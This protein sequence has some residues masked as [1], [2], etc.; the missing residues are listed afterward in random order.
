MGAICNSSEKDKSKPTSRYRRADKLDVK[1]SRGDEVDVK[2]SRGTEDNRPLWS[3]SSNTLPE[4]QLL[5]SYS[6][7]RFAL[8]SSIQ[9]SV[10]ARLAAIPSARL[11]VS[12][13][14]M[15]YLDDRSEGRLH[16]LW[17]CHLP[18]YE[19]AKELPDAGISE[20][21]DYFPDTD[22]SEVCTEKVYWN[23]GSA[24]YEQYYQ[25]PTMGASIWADN[26]R[27]TDP[28]ELTRGPELT[29][30]PSNDLAELVY[31]DLALAS[32]VHALV[33]QGANANHTMKLGGR[34]SSSFDFVDL[35][36]TYVAIQWRNSSV[37]AA[38][39]DSN[40]SVEP[41]LQCS[42]NRFSPGYPLPTLFQ[43]AATCGDAALMEVLRRRGVDTVW[44][45]DYTHTVHY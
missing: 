25:R 44:L 3:P 21:C 13:G 35:P 1:V 31:H 11:S 39:L 45:V 32:S 34:N 37:L 5:T 40:A 36:L 19:L 8:S 22:I 6:A 12:D 18:Q 7:A 24:K 15:G 43:L 38:L 23:R 16:A 41:V 26:G 14:N 28:A 2:V 27:S 20:V 33:A 30:S 29:S 4:L 10:R 42:H 9:Q 17:L